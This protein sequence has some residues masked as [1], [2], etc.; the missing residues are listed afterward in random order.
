MPSER[1]IEC[2]SAEGVFPVSAAANALNITELVT[3][4]GTQGYN[5]QACNVYKGRLQHVLSLSTSLL[6]LSI[7]FLFVFRDDL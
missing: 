6:L 1:A 4:I 3:F 5:I 2:I 7:G